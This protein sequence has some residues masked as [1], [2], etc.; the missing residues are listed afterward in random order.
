MPRSTPLALLVAALVAPAAN[1]QHAQRP[2]PASATTASAASTRRGAPASPGAPAPAAWRQFRGGTDNAGVVPGTLRATWRYR[3]PHAVRGFGVAGDVLVLGTESGDAHLRKFGPDQRGFVAALDLQTGRERWVRE[4]PNWV[5]G[6]PVVADGLAWVTY[7]RFPMNADGGLTAFDLA[8]GT[9]VWSRVT[10]R[11]IMPGP[12]L[13][14]ATGRLVAF[15][16]DDTLR[17]FDART[18][19]LLHA[20]DLHFADAMSSPRVDA[21]GIVYV[22]AESTLVAYDARR[23]WLRW[24]VMPP[25]LIML[26]TPPVALA[27]SLV[28]TEG[29]ERLSAWDAL[30][31]LPLS[32]W[33][34]VAREARA[35]YD[36]R[37]STW[38][39]WYN[40]Q[41]LVAFDARTGAVRWRQP[42]GAGMVVFRNNS[43]TPAVARGRVV[44]SSPVSRT[45]RA[46]D[47]ATGRPLWTHEVPTQHVGAPTIIGD[48]VLLGDKPGQ[49]HVLS[50][51][52]GAEVGQCA[53][54]GPFSP[55]APV[56]VG[57]TLITATR[58][59][60][61]T[62]APWDSVR[63]RAVRRAPCH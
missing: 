55:T 34:Q 38:R 51:A 49:L 2:A 13:D 16:G 25:G 53:M 26:G 23:D 7:G 63:A 10:A 4:V 32:R 28:L 33:V 59:G 50:L 43:G 19:R 62:A 47:L 54:G 60:W 36:G 45:V 18:G 9:P 41:W 56:L 8:T 12:A 3:A 48:D 14:S 46:F 29:T 17:T 1:A 52:T 39:Q 57:E 37:W 20:V 30:R 24:Q 44:I 58:D 21:G 15:G 27:D 61:L 31:L 35:Q 11:G 5:H 42:L 22:G 40:Q 6:D